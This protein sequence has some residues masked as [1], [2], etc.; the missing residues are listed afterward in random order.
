MQRPD[1]AYWIQQLELRSH[2]EGGA[3]REVYRS[4]LTI[5]QKA[6]PVFFQGPRNVSTSIYFLLASGQFS[7]FHRIASDEVWHFYFGDPLLIYEI[8]HAGVLTVHRLGPNIEKGEQ[9]QL[10]IKA[11]SWFASVP[12][13]DSEYALVGCTVAPG[14]DFAEFE[15]ADRATLAQQFPQHR[16]IIEA[17]TR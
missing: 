15:L 12:A 17:L 3:F 14:F 16:G 11:G 9:F 5:A 6:L 13:E 8:G 2:V 10:V 1:A 4:D 7:A